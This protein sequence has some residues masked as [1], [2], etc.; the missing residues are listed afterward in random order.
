[1][2]LGENIS[3][4]YTPIS[5]LYERGKFDILIKIY[6]KGSHPNF[7]EGGILTQWIDKLE[8][9]TDV[10]MKGPK[11][12]LYYYGDGNFKYGSKEK[13]VVWTEKNFNKVGMLCGGT[14]IAP[15]Y[16]LLQAADVNKDTI[17]Y[18]LIFGNRSAHDILLKEEL[19]TM[20]K[21]QN[22]KFNLQYTIDKYEKN[23]EGLVGYITHDKIQKYLPPPSDDTLILLCGRGKMCKKY[24]KPMLIEMGYKPEYIYIF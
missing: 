22:F 20:N 4:K 23:W 2:E 18:S 21:N 3:R 19:D 1:M 17:E 15:F 11:G 24:L 8:I 5:T 16:Q 6:Y 14:G 12:R 7:P 9:G 10:M 13:P